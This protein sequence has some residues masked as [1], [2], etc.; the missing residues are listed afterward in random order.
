MSLL[1][2]KVLPKLNGEYIVR[3]KSYKEITNDKGGYVQIVLQ[4]PDREFTY[5]LF[6]S[7]IEYVARNLRNQ[8][9]IEDET[10]LGELLE[11]AT[12]T[13]FKVWISYNQE[14]NS[15]NVSFH[16]NMM[17]EEEAPEL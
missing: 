4:L 16:N 7:S 12:K 13:D 3:V 15:M 6:P 5:N 8:F 9:G 1:D 2:S 14:Y 17:V 10:T 11:T